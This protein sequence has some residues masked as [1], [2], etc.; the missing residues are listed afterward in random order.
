[1]LYHHGA[2][3]S[4]RFPHKKI[5]E[6]VKNTLITLIV[7]MPKSFFREFMWDILKFYTSFWYHLIHKGYMKELFF[8]LIGVGI[9]FIPSLIK[10]KKVQSQTVIELDYL[11]NLL[12]TEKIE[13]NLP[14]EVFRL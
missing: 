12:Y 6:V 8:G 2:A 4:R 14:D 1:V 13:I 5:K 7:C 9:K 11:R 10:R 3:T